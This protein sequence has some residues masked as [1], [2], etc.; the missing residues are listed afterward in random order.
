MA[1]SPNGKKDALACM[2]TAHSVA[3]VGASPNPEKV[4]HLILANILKGRFEGRVYPINP[5]GGEI[6][7]KRAYRSLGDVPDHIELAVLVIPAP[8]VAGVLREAAASGVGSAVIISGGF[9]EAGRSDLEME[10]SSIVA[11][12]GIRLLGPNCQGFNFRANKLC[13][14]WPLVAKSGPFAV[15]SQSGTVAAVIAGWAVEDG[16]GISATV[17]LGNQVDLCEADFVEFLAD[18]PGT[19]AIGMYLEGVKDGTRFLQVARKAA[20]RKPLVI[21]KS[22]R[23]E[24]GQRAAA[25]HTRS[26]AGRD[27]VFG[28]M[29][30]QLGIVRAPDLDA[31]YDSARILG[32]MPPP[33]GRRLAIVTSSGGSGILAVDA[34]ERCGLETPALDRGLIEKLRQAGLP[35]NAVLSNP[36]DLTM[37]AARDFEAAVQV[38]KPHDVAD[39]FLMIFGDPIPGAAEAVARLREG[40]KLPLAVSYLGGAEVEKS[41]RLLLHSAGV[42]VFSTPERAVRALAA[43]AWYGGKVKSLGTQGRGEQEAANPG[44]R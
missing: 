15:I 3:V 13:A 11:E 42:P 6:L 35:A 4:G 14:S 1:A 41:E 37:C 30:R 23:T 5:A 38:L 17:S 18:D 31:L 2:F 22:G 8:Q 33:R 40:W 32:L 27:E 9:R 7:G 19:K 25:S 16:L 10:L 43:A 29:C 21:L 20:L 26:L 44:G 24:G 39:A 28:G 34:A 36:L 12:T